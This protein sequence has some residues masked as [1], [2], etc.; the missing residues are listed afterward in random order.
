MAGLHPRII[1]EAVASS[2]RAAGLAKEV[3]VFAYEPPTWAHPNSV[4]IY[5]AAGSD[6]AVT[7]GATGL[8]SLALEV[9]IRCTA[10]MRE[11]AERAL[12]DLLAAG[13]GAGSSVWDALNA[14]RT[15]SAAVRTFEFIDYR[16]PTFTDD[17]ALE[18]SYVI[19]VHQ[20]RS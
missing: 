6:Y 5:H 14:D 3:G 13:T 18:A 16:P 19:L 11:E 20:A 17:D 15:F 10:A 7:F 8:A 9:R 12:D 1:R 4:T 2:I